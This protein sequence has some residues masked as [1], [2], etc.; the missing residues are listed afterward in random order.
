MNRTTAHLCLPVTLLLL[1]AGC[2]VRLGGKPLPEVNTELRKENQQLE[3][4]VQG[5]QQQSEADARVIDGLRR[6]RPTVATLPPERLSRLFTTAGLKFGRLTGGADLDRQKPGDEA[7][8]VQ[9]SPVDARGDEL[10][11]AGSFVIE[12]FDTSRPHDARIGHWE[13]PLE[14]AA[15]HWRSVLTQYNYTFTLPWQTPP[16]Q[17]SLHVEVTFFD[18]L[19]QTPIK[20][21]I[22]V[23]VDPPPPPASQPTSAPSPAP[24]NRT[25]AGQ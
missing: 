14:E 10:K 25:V 13:I 24:S 16:N 21:T 1:A 9:V 8:K 4:K 5:L 19:T 2:G 7:L 11:A 3:A 23:K 22:D 20:Q 15:R 18:E 17:E 6:Q 12:A